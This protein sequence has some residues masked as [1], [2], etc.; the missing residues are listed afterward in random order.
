[1]SLELLEKFRD[2]ELCR[3]MLDKMRSELDGDLR[4]MEVCGT[5]TVAIFQSG[6]R[7]LLPEQVVTSER[8]GLPGL[9]HA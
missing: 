9:C 7:S 4:F 3:K 8:S 6:L 1:M 5:H 2:P